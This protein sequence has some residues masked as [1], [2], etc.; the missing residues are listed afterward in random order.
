MHKMNPSN[1]KKL[2]SKE[3][4]KVL[5][6][7]ETLRRFNL[8]EQ[9]IFAD[10]GCGIGY[11]TIPASKIISKNHTAYAMDISQEMLDELKNRAKEQSIENIKIIKNEEYDLK[12]DDKSVTFALICNVLHEMEEKEKMINEAVR[13]LKNNG[14]ILIIEWDK[15]ETPMG[16]PISHRTSKE[17]IKEILMKFELNIRFEDSISNIFYGILAE[18]R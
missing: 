5:P 13:I 15:K 6:P 14:K 12:L 10:I 18:K 17:E 2:D 1:K 8:K 4:R 11:F 9:D 16:P 3:R 7:E